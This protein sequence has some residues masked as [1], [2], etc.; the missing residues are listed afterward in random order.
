MKSILIFILLS[1]LTF[2]LILILDLLAG[3]RLAV[4][5]DS[6]YSVLVTTTMQ[7]YVIMIA[8]L[9]YPFFKAILSA[10]QKTK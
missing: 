3:I 5:F 4:L 9:I 6:I 10:L 2:S 1:G 7:E 8:F